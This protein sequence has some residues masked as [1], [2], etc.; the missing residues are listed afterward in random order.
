MATKVHPRFFR[1]GSKPHNF[2][3]A[4]AFGQ[5]EHDVPRFHGTHV[6]VQCFARVQEHGTRARGI[7][8][9]RNFGG[10]MCTLSHSRDHHFAAC[11]SKV[12]AGMLK[13]SDLTSPLWIPAL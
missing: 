9:G 4:A 13:E 8:S 2:I 3:A 1:V 6:A 5:A 10:N 12:V 7:E 11:T